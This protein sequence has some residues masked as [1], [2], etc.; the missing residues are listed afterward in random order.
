MKQPGQNERYNVFLVDDHAIF[1]AGLKNLIDEVPA[2]QV[3]AEASDG[4]DLFS[5]LERVNCDLVILDLSMPNLG[6]IQALGKLKSDYPRIKVLILSMHDQEVY[7]KQAV[8]KKTNGY[9]LKTDVFDS[10]ITG[11]KEIRAGRKYFSKR[12]IPIIVNEYGNI[13]DNPRSIASLTRRE[14]EILKL[15]ANGLTNRGISDKLGISKRT[16]ETHRYHVMEKLQ[17][18]TMAELIKFAIYEDLV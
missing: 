11:I 13:Y 16:V 10:L 12:L 9:V 15:V 18:E 4:E 3:V 17:I 14:V 8:A 2:F 7:L 6:G 5:Q 1:R